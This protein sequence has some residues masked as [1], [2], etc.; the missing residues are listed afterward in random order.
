MLE[1]FMRHQVA[2]RRKLVSW[3][4]EEILMAYA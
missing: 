4:F 3:F 1:S 2:Q